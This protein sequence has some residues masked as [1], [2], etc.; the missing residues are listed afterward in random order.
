MSIDHPSAIDKDRQTNP[1]GLPPLSEKD[2]ISDR[3]SLASLPFWLWIG[4]TAIVFSLILGSN[5][6]FQAFIQNEKKNDPFLEV[7]NREFSLFLWQFSSFSRPHAAKKSGY[8]PGFETTSQNVFFSASEEFVVAPPDLI[9]LYHTWHRLLASDLIQRPISPQEFTQFLAQLP[10]WNPENWKGAPK[11][12]IQLIDSKEFFQ[13]NDLQS[14][15][16]STLPIAVRQ[17]FLGW[18]NYYM[19]GIQINALE[20]TF[21]QL[22]EFLEKHPHYARNDWRNIAE[23]HEQKI[24]GLDYLAGF[25]HGT[26]IPDAIVPKNQLAPFLKVAFYNA[27]QAA[28]KQ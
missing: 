9:F 28:K 10:E 7:T 1:S 23:I 14:L 13:L 17:A 3:W 16:Q 5:N 27:E 19:E 2:F 21:G 18:K 4:L 6:W 20:P 25:V 15:P 8:L 22:K 12:Y 11:A 24:A 26:F